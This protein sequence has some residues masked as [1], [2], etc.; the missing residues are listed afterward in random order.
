M[1]VRAIYCAREAAYQ[2]IYGFVH[3][4]WF[5]NDTTSDDKLMKGRRLCTENYTIRLPSLRPL[6]FWHRRHL[7][8]ELKTPKA[9]VTKRRRRVKKMAKKGPVQ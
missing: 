2:T 4:V 5:R 6:G 1:T 9:D 7:R 3:L 8:R